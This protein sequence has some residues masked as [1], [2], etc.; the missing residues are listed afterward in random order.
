LNM[1]NLSNRELAVRTVKIL[2]DSGACVA[3]A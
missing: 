3:L 2:V 1:R